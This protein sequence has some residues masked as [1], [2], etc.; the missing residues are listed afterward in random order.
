[1][2]A[3]PRIDP[4]LADFLAQQVDLLAAG[5][6]AGLAE[7]YA[8]DAVLVRFDRTARGRA[9]IRQLLADHAARSPEVIEHQD[10][11]TTDDVILYQSRQL[12]DGREVVAVGTF[13]FRDGLVWRQTAVFVETV[14]LAP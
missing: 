6:A 9:E 8:E 12:M 2:T 5:D 11:V 10:L 1:M 7:R 14:V 4:R 13:A 3:Q